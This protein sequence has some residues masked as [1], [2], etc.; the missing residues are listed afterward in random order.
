MNDEK[1]RLGGRWYVLPAARVVGR[2][3]C[4]E[5]RQAAQERLRH[6]WERE[7]ALAARASVDPG[8][9]SREAIH[10]AREEQRAAVALLG[11]W[12]A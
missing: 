2:R 7:G 9:V 1:V 11:E 3:A 10:S 8:S 5:R 4:R 6:A 12:S